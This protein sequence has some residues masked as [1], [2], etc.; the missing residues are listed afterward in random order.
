M[1]QSHKPGNDWEK[2][3]AELAAAV[4][5]TE[6]ARQLAARHWIGLGR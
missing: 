6:A 1:K 5:R 2:I 4:A 3:D